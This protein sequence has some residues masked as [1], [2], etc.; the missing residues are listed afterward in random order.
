MGRARGRC[1]RGSSSSRIRLRPDVSHTRTI[2]S[3]T[4]V[5][6]GSCGLLSAAPRSPEA[7]GPSARRPGPSWRLCG[8]TSHRPP[9]T[10]DAWVHW[11]AGTA[12]NRNW[13][14]CWEDVPHA[15]G[16]AV[17]SFQVQFHETTGRIVF[18][19]ASD[20]GDGSWDGL[21]YSLGAASDD[22]AR[23]ANARRRL[24]GAGRTSR[25]GLRIRSGR[26]HGQRTSADGSHR[27]RHRWCGQH[28][29][30]GRCRCGSGRRVASRGRDGPGAGF[31]AVTD[32]EGDFEITGLAMD[33]AADAE[34][35][36][37]ARNDACWVSDYPTVQAGAELGSPFSALIAA[38]IDLSANS[39][40]GHPPPRRGQR[41]DC[42]QARAPER[43][44]RDR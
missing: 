20:P 42:G 19:Y 39:G 6:T 32:A 2:A 3:C 29:A 8:T 31:R 44:S 23:S 25:H 9:P 5:K 43:S 27:R 38:G 26:R 17:P 41:P 33:A 4:S 1:L 40:P 37:H 36:V 7:T 15:T 22:G 10:V 34:L 13:I 35:L 18:A 21:T 14:V 28:G 30:R 16:I 11:T 12:P 24:L